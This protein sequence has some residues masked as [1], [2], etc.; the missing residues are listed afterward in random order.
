GFLNIKSPNKTIFFETAVKSVSM[1]RD[2]MWISTGIGGL[3][4]W[5]PNNKLKIYNC[6]QI[7]EGRTFG[8]FAEKNSPRVWV[9]TR[10]G[11]V[12][13]ANGKGR[14]LSF[15]HPYLENRIS[16]IKQDKQGNIWMVVD[17]TDLVIIKPAL[18]VLAVIDKEM[19]FENEK[20]KRIFIDDENKIWFITNHSLYQVTLEN[21]VLQ[22]KT[23]LSLLST[24]ILND[25]LVDKEKIWLASTSGVLVAPKYFEQDQQ[26]K[27]Y[28][29]DIFLNAEKIDLP[30][31]RKIVVPHD[32]NNLKIN[33]TGL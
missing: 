7:Y 1:R 11:L 29:T 4:V 2:T 33:F 18:S 8:V 9:G 24:Y 10:D 19:G 6:V 17:A 3:R 15:L 16:Q 20:C 26:I 30:D 21:D 28:L 14:N 12:L 23:I 5:T 13:Y 22:L 31:G 27:S 32:R 25:V